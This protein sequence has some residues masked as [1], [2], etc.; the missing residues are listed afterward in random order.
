MLVPIDL[1]YPMSLVLFELFALGDFT[2]QTR[3]LTLQLPSAE[4]HTTL[5]PGELTL[6]YESTSSSEPSGKPDEW[7]CKRGAL[8]NSTHSMWQRADLSSATSQRTKMRSAWF[9]PGH[10]S[11]LALSSPLPPE[12]GNERGSRQNCKFAGPSS[13]STSKQPQQAAAPRFPWLIGATLN[14]GLASLRAFRSSPDIHECG[15]R[16]AIFQSR[17]RSNAKTPS[18]P[19][20]LC[21]TP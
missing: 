13:S 6:W 10:L 14:C 19:T 3:P 1:P 20:W 18:N 15:A 2:V 7:P 8:V 17:R 12:L 4:V 16:G 11:V 21:L 5:P 9:A